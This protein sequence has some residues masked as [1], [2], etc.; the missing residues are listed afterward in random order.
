M[1]L[2]QRANVRPFHARTAAPKLPCLS[3]TAMFCNYRGQMLND[4][5]NFK[6]LSYYCDCFRNVICL[7]IRACSAA[8][9]CH[10]AIRI[11]TLPWLPSSEI[12]R[13]P[14]VYL[15]IRRY[16]RSLQNIHQNR[17]A[18]PLFLPLR[19]GSF[20]IL[21]VTAERAPCSMVSVA[22]SVTRTFAHWA[23]STN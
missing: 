6:K 2:C 22:P 10:N 4:A 13:C 19:L 20:T 15:C 1:P 3:L 9:S 8:L 16:F 5:S 11:P 12:V 14:S 7:S 18:R 23:Q 17:Y 21:Q